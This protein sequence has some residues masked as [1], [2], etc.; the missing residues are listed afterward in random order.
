MIGDAAKDIRE[1]SLRIDTIELGRFDQR[2]RA[3]HCNRRNIAAHMLRGAAFGFDATLVLRTGTEP[4]SGQWRV[5]TPA[6]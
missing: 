1:P 4:V 2:V 5:T 6:L 3:S